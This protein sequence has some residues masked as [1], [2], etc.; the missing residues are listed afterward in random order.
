ASC[1][2]CHWARQFA[3][4]QM[5]L[6]RVRAAQ[7]I[8]RGPNRERSTRHRFRKIQ[9]QAPIA[10]PWS[11]IPEKPGTAACTVP[12][13]RSVLFD[14]DARLTSASLDQEAFIASG[15]AT[16]GAEFDDLIV[17]AFHCR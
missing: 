7:D 14:A 4:S 15:I 3:A 10:S 11:T 1:R 8:Y 17:F 13:G 2:H 9:F 6:G 12:G 5:P 16:D